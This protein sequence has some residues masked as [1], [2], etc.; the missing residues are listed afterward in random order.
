MPPSHD[1]LFTLHRYFV[2][3]GEMMTQLMRIF[4]R[5]KDQ[6]TVPVLRRVM[7]SIATMRWPRKSKLDE[8]RVFLYLS[9]WY[10][11]LYVVIE[12]WN[13]LGLH[14]PAVDRLLRSSNVDLLRQYRNAVFHYHRRYYDEKFIALMRDGQNG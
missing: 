2:W 9:Y 14:D 11:G 8:L 1:E 7:K 3:A 6:R 4:V 13:N 12:G 5:G 10:A